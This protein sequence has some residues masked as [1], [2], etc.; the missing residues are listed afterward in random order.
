MEATE[1]R[2]QMALDSRWHANRLRL[3]LI[4]SEQFDSRGGAIAGVSPVPEVREGSSN[5]E[6]LDAPVP[7]DETEPA[8]AVSPVDA[9]ALEGTLTVHLTFYVCAGAPPGQSY[10]GTMASGNTAY[11]GAAACGYGMALGT[12]FRIVG[13]ATG[14][15]Y[16]CEDRGAGPSWWIDVF[17]YDYANGRAWRNQFG[18]SVEI[19]LL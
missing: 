18:K 10:C 4:R 6:P 17:W 15:T 19:V 16:T 13:D 1:I 3:A 7:T 12:L 5:G 8:P 14:R 2:G 11:E 9:P